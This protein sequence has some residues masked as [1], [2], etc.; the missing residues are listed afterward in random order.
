MDTDSQ[1]R[2]EVREGIALFT[3]DCP[4][5]RN[6]ATP[7]IMVRLSQA[8]RE[9]RTRAEWRVAIVTG[10]GER[11][12]CAGADLKRS[13]PLSSGAA[14]PQDEWERQL[15][16]DRRCFTDW[17]LFDFELDKPVISALNGDAL[18][19]GCE[20]MLASDLRIAA[21]GVQIGLVEPRRG[22]VPG[23]GGVQRLPRQLPRAIALELLLT[24]EPIA[25]ERALQLG[26]LNRLVPRERLL[27][28]A[29]ALARNVAS[30]GPLALAAIKRTLRLTE[31]MPIDAALRAGQE[32]LLPVFSS[33]DAEE[34]RRAFLE[35]RPPR[36]SGR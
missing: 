6:A 31:C 11:S 35:K 34:G 22:L 19:G 5:Q 30:N 14:E 12:F 21:A 1:L 17:T 18:G 20:L 4:A 25:A 15:V 24:A 23:G 7:E 32:L 33:A 10:T 16:A 9:F 29:L 36:W 8:W 3:L 28:E 2:I 13:L 26:L 27:D